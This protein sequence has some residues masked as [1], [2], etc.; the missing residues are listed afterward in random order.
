MGI[1]DSPPNVEESTEPPLKGHYPHHELKHPTNPSSQE[2]S[3]AASRVEETTA[4]FELDAIDANAARDR[5]YALSVQ[6]VLRAF[7]VDPE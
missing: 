5:P 1:G 2:I 6:T 3:P 4:Q 7:E